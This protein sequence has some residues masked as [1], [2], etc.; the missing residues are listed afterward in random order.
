MQ[1]FQTRGN[2][3]ELFEEF[4]VGFVGVFEAGDGAC[5]KVLGICLCEERVQSS[6]CV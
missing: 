2:D 1:R 3:V 5:R 4:E 6:L